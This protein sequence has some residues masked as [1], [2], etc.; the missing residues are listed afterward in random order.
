MESQPVKYT[1]TNCVRVVLILSLFFLTSMTGCA[2]T[3][4]PVMGIRPDYPNLSP[5]PEVV[6]WC[7]VAPD[8][9]TLSCR[10]YRNYHEYAN[11]LSASYRSRA[12]LNEW[13]L[14]FAGLVGLSGLTATAGLAATNAGIQ[15][16]RIVPLVTGFV[17]GTTAVVENKDKALNYTTAAN[18]IDAA[19]DEAERLVASRQDYAAAFD[20]L[21]QKVTK[22]KNEL[23][24][25]KVELAARD[26]QLEKLVD[27]KIK[28]R[29]PN[30]LRL[31]DEDVDIPVGTTYALKVEDGNSVDPARTTISKP[32][33][34]DVSY[35]S[36]NQIISITGRT[37]GQTSIKFRDKNGI[38]ASVF[39]E[40]LG[41]TPLTSAQATPGGTVTITLAE[42]RKMAYSLPDGITG[43]GVTSSVPNVALGRLSDDRKWIIIEAVKKQPT[44]STSDITIGLKD[45]NGVMK[46]VVTVN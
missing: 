46:F 32:A 9:A 13:G 3:S 23:E 40:V 19:I 39:V 36:N 2:T 14:Y 45:K 6:E 15:A 7:K 42:G 31:A 18:A 26:K 8:S 35:S 29:L 27:E 33:I 44:A 12:T 30:Q 21:S 16:L 25:S 5:S 17:S 10:M 11:T 1:R 28:A 20:H 34:V 24:S 41:A 4:F 22:A 38:S 43:D 37:Q